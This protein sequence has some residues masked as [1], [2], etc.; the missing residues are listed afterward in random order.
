MMS[1]GRLALTNGV[2]IPK[3][4]FGGGIVHTYRHSDESIFDYAKYK[5]K[6]RLKNKKQY[7][8]DS[9]FTKNVHIC[10]QNGITMFDTSKA[11]RDG[12]YE[13]GRALKSYSRDDYFIVT[14]A[15]NTDQFNGDIRKALEDSLK[16][17]DMTYVD[18]YLLHWPVTDIWVNSWLEMEKLYQEGLCKAI[19]VCNCN[20][21]HLE[22]L[23]HHAQIL[24][25][26]NEFE[27]HPLFTQESLR[28][29]C[30]EKHIQVMAYTATARM[31][32]R[33]RKTVLVPIA[34]KY[35]KTI[36]QI[37]LKWHQQIGNIP[38]F[39]SSNP[40]HVK[41]NAELSDFTL[42]IDEIKMISAININSRLR[43]DPDNCD[44][45]QL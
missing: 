9:N 38:I 28:S 31:D 20:I 1:E 34:Q 43:Y 39:N 6:T 33:L 24:P 2:V 15:S 8:L 11:Y 32:E 23:K 17:L 4:C 21:H 36:S 14:K 37:I 26:V 5:M 16:A 19:G 40:E 41:S 25:M 35:N 13:L 12:E 29:Y 45:R 42:T 7:L 22:E 30:E 27:C 3:I 10:M 18:L 44:F